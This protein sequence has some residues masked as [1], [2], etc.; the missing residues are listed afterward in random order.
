MEKFNKTYKKIFW[1]LSMFYTLLCAVCLT[2]GF[3]T[4]PESVANILI[5]IFFF[6]MIPAGL[7]ELINFTPG[8][9]PDN[10]VILWL[11]IYLSSIIF[12]ALLSLLITWLITIYTRIMAFNHRINA[13]ES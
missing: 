13:D 3:L 7:V 5:I 12:S 11:A 1:R 6:L 8:F 10:P 4:I 2:L 9:H